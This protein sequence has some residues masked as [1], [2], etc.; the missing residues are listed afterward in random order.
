MQYASVALVFGSI[1]LLAALASAQCEDQKLLASDGDPN[2]W[3]GRSVAI[4]GARLIVGARLDDDNGHDSGSVYVYE[5]GSSGW[6]EVAK[7]VAQVPE[8]GGEFGS[9]VALSGDT[10]V[11][12]SWLDDVRGFDS[13]SAFVFELTAF[14]WTQIAEL[15]PPELGPGDY[16]GSAVSVDG[17]RLVVAA[18]HDKGLAGRSGTAYV[19]ERAGSAWLQTAKLIAP[20]GQQ[21]DELGRAVSLSGDR[22]LLGAYKDG[23]L[24]LNAG[25]AYVF[26]YNGS[27]WNYEAKL[28]AAE[29]KA[30]D[31]FG[32]TVSLDGDRALVGGEG[33]AFEAAYVFERGAGGWAETARLVA[34]NSDEF[35]LYGA[36]VSVRG[37]RVLVA[38]RGHDDDGY[39]NSGSA[40]LYEWSGGAWTEVLGFHACDRHN[41]DHFGVSVALGEGKAV[42]G[43]IGDI[44]HSRGSAYVFT[45]ERGTSYCTAA[46]NS[47]GFGALITAPGYL[48][49][50]ISKNE[51]VLRTTPVPDEPGLFFYG[52]SQI[53]QPFGDGYRCVGGGVFRILPVTQA[54]G[55]VLERAVDFTTLPAGGE[56]TAGSTWNFQA[57]YRDPAAGGTGFNLSNGL[58]LTFVP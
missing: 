45:F 46:T 28:L 49:P 19:F 17:D 57:W 5:L 6:T 12:G 7:L 27:S 29:G 20:D 8:T 50:S 30:H 22:V 32:G 37:D 21:G 43:T 15:L 58:E 18:Q 33:S 56:I 2:D 47:T 53:F 31:Y 39:H 3:Y 41:Y 24:G 42:V 9:S 1:S 52:S 36:A 16:Y 14:G 4:D 40:Y 35:D 54:T 38:A 13:G 26:A 51:L 34:S 48:A 25:S 10:I 44:D 55:G 23:D 11:V